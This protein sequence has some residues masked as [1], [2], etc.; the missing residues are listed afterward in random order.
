ME[1]LGKHIIVKN[2]PQKRVTE[3][4]I[5]I[6]DSVVLETNEAEVIEV[7]QDC[8]VNVGDIVLISPALPLPLDDKLVITYN[9][10]KYNLTTDEVVGDNLVVKLVVEEKVGNI[11]LPA[12][13]KTP[14]VIGEKGELN[15]KSIK[16]ETM[17]IQP[18]NVC[19]FNEFNIIYKN[20]VLCII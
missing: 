20:D 2:V 6:P 3:S 5:I 17:M 4:G 16:G 10:V 15:G 13:K 12:A 14:F 1:I 19:K 11:F 9:D 7:G 8:P 18:G